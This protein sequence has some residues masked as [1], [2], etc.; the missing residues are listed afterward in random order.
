MTAA[1]AQE[2]ATVRAWWVHAADDVDD[3]VVWL[4]EPSA[5]A[6]EWLSQYAGRLFVVK[7]LAEH[8]PRRAA[9]FDAVGGTA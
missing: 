4:N 7:P 5:E 8:D 3:G 2:P 9:G 6:L 1:T